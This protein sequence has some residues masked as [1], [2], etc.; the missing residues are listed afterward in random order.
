MV[1]ITAKNASEYAASR[2]AVIFCSRINAL[3][4]GSR[5]VRS[6]T[7]HLLEPGME[8][9]HPGLDLARGGYAGFANFSRSGWQHLGATGTRLPQLVTYKEFPW[10]RLRFGRLVST[11]QAYS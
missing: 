2:S 10:A 1:T 5:S 11:S 3:L 9:S 4:M 6:G 8:V 7:R